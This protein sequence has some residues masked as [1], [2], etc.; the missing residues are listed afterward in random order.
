MWGQKIDRTGIFAFS[1]Y[2]QNFNFLSKEILGFGQ[3]FL[4]YGFD[5]DHVSRALKMREEKIT[6][7]NKAFSYT[8]HCIFYVTYT[9][10][11]HK[12]LLDSIETIG[13]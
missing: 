13:L 4:G 6:R 1:A 12:S 8:Q 2:L 7:I 10:C 3:I 11:G 9:V 5:R